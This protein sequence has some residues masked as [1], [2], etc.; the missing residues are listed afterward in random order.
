MTISMDIEVTVLQN[1]TGGTPKSP[2]VS[3]EIRYNI[4]EDWF[5]IDR[6]PSIPNLHTAPYV[7]HISPMVLSWI[8]MGPIN[9]Y[10]GA[11]GT[12][13]L[14]HSLSGVYWTPG[15]ELDLGNLLSTVGANGYVSNLHIASNS[16]YA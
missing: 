15:A 4:W 7:T 14:N 6:N 2:P 12:S 5:G 9:I 10:M 16:I 1:L 11:E 3:G 8:W 13:W